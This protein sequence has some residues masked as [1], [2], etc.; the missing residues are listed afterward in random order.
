M[1]A[2]SSSQVESANYGKFNLSVGEVSLNQPCQ[3]NT[4]LTLK[5]LS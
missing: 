3:G 5:I 4:L 1:V 2:R